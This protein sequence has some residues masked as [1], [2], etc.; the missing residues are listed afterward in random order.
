MFTT[1]EKV[2]IL[3]SLFHDIGKFEQRCTGNKARIRH[4]S[5]SRSLIETDDISGI[6]RKILNTD[7]SY[8]MLLDVISQHHDRKPVQELTNYLKT[9][10]RL[11]ASERVDLDKEDLDDDK[12]SHKYLLSLFSKLHLLNSNKVDRGYYRQEYLTKKNYRIIIPRDESNIGETGYSDKNWLDFIDDLKSVLTVYEDESDFCSLINALLMLFEKYMWCVPDFTGSAVTDISLYN[13]SKDVSGIALAHYRTR[14][15]QADSSKLMLIA[16]DIPGIQK[17]IFDINNRKAAKLLRGR[18]IN[19]QILSRMF[20]THF[21]TEL[22]LTECNLIMLAGGKFYI[23]APATDE[24]RSTC[25]K[26]KSEIEHY[27]FDKM[28]LQLE[29]IYG[30][31]EFDIEEL[32]TKKGITFG[33]IVEQCL[34]D[35]NSRKLQAFNGIL[36]SKGATEEKFVLG[37]YIHTDE[38]EEKVKCFLS[39]KPIMNKNGNPEV[40]RVNGVE[41]NVDKQ[42]YNEYLIGER[43]TQNNL[44]IYVGKEFEINPKE[45]KTFDEELNIS[46]KNKIILNPELDDLII[47]LRGKNNSAKNLF[48]NSTFIEV[49][50]FVS[51]LSEDDAEKLNEELTEEEE[52][53]PDDIMSFEDMKEKSRGAKYLSIVKGD[54]DNLGLLMAF[55]LTD[56]E[57]GRDLTGISRTTTLSF[58]LRYYFSTFV[59]GYLSDKN[60]YDMHHYVENRDSTGKVVLTSNENYLKDKKDTGLSQDSFSYVIYAGGDDLLFVC[61]QSYSH[62]LVK[63][64]NESFKEFVCRNPEVHISYSI[65]NFKHSTPIRLVAELSESN[66]E[67]A[68]EDGRSFADVLK[69]IDQQTDSFFDINNKSSIFSFESNFKTDRLEILLAKSE[70]LENWVLREKLSMGMIRLLLDYNRILKEYEDSKRKNTE[71]LI[72]L[73]RLTYSI[74]RNL[75][76]SNDT[77]KQEVRKFFESFIS[78]SEYSSNELKDIILPI[79]CST[80]YKIRKTN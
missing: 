50:S 80:I 74:N 46:E 66:Q 24:T 54:I 3:G 1:E 34:E 47:G 22:K 58:H 39:D 14:A 72:M 57:T 73:P 8:K 19:I 76:D 2:L 33:D 37:D 17:Y 11:S 29:F 48:R 36:F 5:L 78:L 60:L 10:D 45:I 49:A 64:F 77:E 16:G 31:S 32:T 20:A 71:K 65:T 6:I 26:A 79:L 41:H 42:V 51:R 4:Q 18:S 69:S 7:D 38:G 9:A 15:T 13:H 21:L 52:R 62:K 56:D 30:I 44:I 12:W 43:I 63:E 75:K 70:E 55:G 68:K 23:I 40:I 27:L 28:N 59:N 61:P 35:M 67:K 53:Y 25:D